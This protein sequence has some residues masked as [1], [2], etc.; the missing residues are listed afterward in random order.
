MRLIGGSSIPNFFTQVHLIY[1]GYF[2]CTETIE[3][4]YRTGRIFHTPK[5]ILRRG[6]KDDYRTGF[7]FIP[8]VFPSVFFYHLLIN[9]PLS[10]HSVVV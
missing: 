1:K 8:A 4:V 3:V 10:Y 5:I 2:Y 6:K 7:S 9:H